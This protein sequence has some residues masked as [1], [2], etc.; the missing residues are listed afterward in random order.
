VD[1]FASDLGDS[2]QAG[3]HIRCGTV[4]T[5]EQER[6]QVLGLAQER[7]CT[8]TRRQSIPCR[9]G[10]SEMEILTDKWGDAVGPDRAAA[11]SGV[12]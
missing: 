10:V 3:E 11:S 8:V 1:T 7:P 9:H 12:G 2:H 4:P 5:F 6:N